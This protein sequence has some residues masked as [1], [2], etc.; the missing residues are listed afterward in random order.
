MDGAKDELNVAAEAV[1]IGR[2]SG[3][4]DRRSAI[5]ALTAGVRGAV[6]GL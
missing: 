5:L 4:D 6:G 1:V 3:S 2:V